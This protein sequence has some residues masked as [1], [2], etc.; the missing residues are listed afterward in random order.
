MFFCFARSR[1]HTSCALV[2]GVQAFALPISVPF[3]FLRS[4]EVKTGGYQAEYGRAT[5]GIINAVSK[6]GTNDLTVGLHLNWEPDGLAS[7]S[8]DTYRRTEERSV[9]T[10]CVST[11]RSR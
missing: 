1:R 6:A 11:C 5:G 7:T 2:T 9:G 4:V 3:E 8:P 10:E